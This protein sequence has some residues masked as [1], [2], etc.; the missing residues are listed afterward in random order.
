VPLSLGI[1]AAIIAA[2]VGV[3]LREDARHVTL[4]RDLPRRVAVGAA[5]M[6]DGRDSPGVGSQDAALRRAQATAL[7]CR[8]E[9]PPHGRQRH[10]GDAVD[11]RHDAAADGLSQRTSFMLANSAFPQQAGAGN[12]VGNPAS[13]GAR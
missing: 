8:P 3:S 4:S 13:A 10:D 7:E 9:N 6:P 11:V 5:T 1:V 12:G 2:S